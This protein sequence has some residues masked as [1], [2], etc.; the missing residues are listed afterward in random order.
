MTTTPQVRAL[1]LCEDFRDEA[2]G[3]IALLGVWGSTCKFSEPAPVVMPTLVAYAHLSLGDQPTML[4]VE[5]EIPGIEEPVQTELSVPASQGPEG[6]DG[7]NVKLKILGV[8]IAHAGDIVLRVRLDEVPNSEREF[9]L[10]L[11]F[12]VAVAG[13]ATA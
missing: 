8:P 6:P 12:P 7:Q 3:K 10:H 4:R 9:R 13:A 1:L 5:L 11:R 2:N